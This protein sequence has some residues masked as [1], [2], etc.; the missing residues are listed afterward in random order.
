MNFRDIYKQP[1]TSKSYVMPFGKYAGNTIETIVEEWCDA[2]YLVWLHHNTDFELSA[3]LL[4]ECEGWGKEQADQ[5][6]REKQ[7]FKA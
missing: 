6:A 4:D 1:V 2:Q 7:S 3:D 5:W